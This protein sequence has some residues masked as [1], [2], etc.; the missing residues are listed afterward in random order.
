M[1]KPTGS[2]S[3]PLHLER[4]LQEIKTLLIKAIDERKLGKRFSLS[5]YLSAF[6]ENDYSHLSKSFSKSQ[7]VTIVQYF[8]LLRLEKVKEWLSYGELSLNEIAAELGYSSV[9]HLSG[10]FKKVVGISTSE[11]KKSF[12]AQRKFIDQVNVP[13]TH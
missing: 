3:S 11:F 13:E 4:Q 6:M 12:S 9:Q 1:K 10:Q 8:I 7:G 2:K 5:K